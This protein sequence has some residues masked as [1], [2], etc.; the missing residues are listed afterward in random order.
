MREITLRLKCKVPQFICHR[1]SCHNCVIAISKLIVGDCTMTRRN[2]GEK[3]PHCFGHY[4]KQQDLFGN[5]ACKNC[6]VAWDCR[7]ESERRARRKK[8]PFAITMPSFEEE[9][10]TK[11]D[12]GSQSDKGH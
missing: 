9:E 2:K 11:R 3:E 4:G 1:K 10:N 8:P 12:D 7:M 5:N 6:P